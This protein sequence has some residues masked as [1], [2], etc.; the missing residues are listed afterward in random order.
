MR[1]P[2]NTLANGH[3]KTTS[4]TPLTVKRQLLHSVLELREVGVGFKVAKNKE[5]LDINFK[6]GVFDI[7]PLYIDDNTVPVP[8]NFLA[9]EQCDL[10]AEPFFTDFFIFYNSL[11]NSARDVE[12]LHTSGIIH[13][14]LGSY[15]D[16]VNLISKVSREIVF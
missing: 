14:L 2:D 9:Y 7:P 10:V 15:K 13:H 16:V 11:I 4:H 6:D 12:V 8:L 5:L 3:G 1:T